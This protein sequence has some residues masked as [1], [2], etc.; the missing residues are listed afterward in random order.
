MNKEIKICIP[1][2]ENNIHREYIYKKIKKI[3]AGKIQSFVEKPLKSERKFKKIFIKMKIDPLNAMG[4]YIL[5]HFSK[6]Q[7]I[8]LVYHHEH[9]WRLLE[10]N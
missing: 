5:D 10:T 4:A 3:N 1:R 9:Y 6:G 7:C 8:K 2:V